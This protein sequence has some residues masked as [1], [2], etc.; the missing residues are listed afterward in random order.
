MALKV[1]FDI[2]LKLLKPNF[3]IFK[4][5]RLKRDNCGTV[6][7]CGTDNCSTVGFW[8]EDTKDL[9]PNSIIEYKYGN[10]RLKYIM[11]SKVEWPPT[12][13]QRGLKIQKVLY[14]GLD[15]TPES[16]AFAGP[17]QCEFHPMSIFKVYKKCRFKFT[18]FGFKIWWCDYMEVS[19]L[20]K[21]KLVIYRS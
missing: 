11:Q 16:K 9:G 7:N 12:F 3:S 2:F 19:S 14:D 20:D 5:Q 17:L 1:V 4:I 18:L 13:T 8:L 15:K 21:N 6:D 10:K